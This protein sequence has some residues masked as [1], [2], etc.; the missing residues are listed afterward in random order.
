MLIRLLPDLLALL[1]IIWGVDGVVDANDDDQR[2][3]EGHENAIRIQRLSTM[4]LAPS[5][6]IK[7][8]HFDQSKE[9]VMVM[10]MVMR[11]RMRKK[12]NQ[13]PS[14]PKKNKIKAGRD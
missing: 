12:R 10:V 14:W 3:G 6:G 9:K 13:N 2:P 5:K 1:H 7:V 11:M 8:D 4:C